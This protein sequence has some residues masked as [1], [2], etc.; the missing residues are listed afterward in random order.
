MGSH[1]RRLQANSTLAGKIQYYRETRKRAQDNN[2]TPDYVYHMGHPRANNPLQVGLSAPLSML[3]FRR[4]KRMISSLQTESCSV[5]SCE[6]IP[7][8]IAKPP[9][10][11]KITSRTVVLSDEAQHQCLQALEARLL[12]LDATYGSLVVMNDGF[13]NDIRIRLGYSF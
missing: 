4:K 7:A 12:I 13:D 3:R 6:A 5:R 2:Y 9:W 10:L 8:Q 1:V 11:H